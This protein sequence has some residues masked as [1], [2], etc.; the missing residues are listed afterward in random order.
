VQNCL[1]VALSIFV[2]F[3]FARSGSGASSGPG[4]QNT[5]SGAQQTNNAQQSPQQN[6]QSGP[7]SGQPSGITNGTLPIEATILAYKALTAGAHAMA[8]A[9]NRKARGRVVVIG[10]SSDI[11][12]IIQ[13]RT[14]L[15]QAR[16][17]K[18]RLD[19]LEAKLGAISA[20]PA[21]STPPAKP[22][23]ALGGA[24]PFIST[25]SDVATLIQTLG[26]I[27]SVNETLS[28]SAAALNDATLISLLADMIDKAPA[29]S[30]LVP[31]VFPPNLMVGT[32]LS[33]TNLGQALSDLENARMRAVLLAIDY[34]QA[35]ADAQTVLAAPPPFTDADRTLAGQFSEK[36]AAINSAVGLI[37]TA[38]TAADTFEN[39]LFTGQGSAPSGGAAPSPNSPN[40]SNLAPSAAAPVPAPLPA[41]VPAPLPA[42][43]PAP[44]VPTPANASPSSPMGSQ[45]QGTPVSPTQPGTVLQQIL[46]ADLLM[47]S[48]SLPPNGTDQVEL[49]AVHA[50]ESGGSQLT[51]SNLFLGS[52][53]YFS[54]GA[55]ASFSLY[56]MDGKLQCSGV[57]YGYRG[58]IREKDLEQK[59]LQ[60]AHATVTT[61][62]Q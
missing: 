53:Y 17:L 9:V 57:S 14:V 50:L 25:P 60:E 33:G 1:S 35:L 44:V 18:D 6:N 32:D 23:L 40:S 41:P 62:C 3:G 22:G 16:I 15:G 34:S 43:A 12:A 45:N 26:S 42:P 51:K 36:A 20:L 29:G 28:T 5:N 4:S 11:A 19:R 61:A 27:T 30:V 52:R 13:L 56:S 2:F 21:Y 24:A 55:V 54:G 46:Y 38:T 39:S 8:T 47:R 59:L 31:S 48:I 10:T 49:L 37:A 7:P 58:F